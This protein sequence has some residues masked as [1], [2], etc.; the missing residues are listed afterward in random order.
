ML[1]CFTIA[2]E[3][4][5]KIPKLDEDITKKKKKERNYR[6]VFLRNID[7]NLSNIMCNY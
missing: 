1:Q 2:I 5:T 3:I 7:V 6:P 4:L